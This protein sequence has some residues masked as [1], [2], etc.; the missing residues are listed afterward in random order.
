MG[1]NK[2]TPVKVLHI[3]IDRVH[4]TTQIEYLY[5]SKAAIFPLGR[6]QNEAGMRPQVVNKHSGKGKSSKPTITSS[7]I[8][9]AD[10]NM[11]HLGNC[12]AQFNQ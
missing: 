7:Q 10:G 11:F 9:R 1:K 8:L 4:Q 12:N 2:G 5:S 6:V 3:N